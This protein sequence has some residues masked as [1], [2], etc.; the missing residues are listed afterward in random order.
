MRLYTYCRRCGRRLKGEENRVRGYGEICYLKAQ[1][2]SETGRLFSTEPREQTEQRESES[3]DRENSNGIQI[4]L[5]PPHLEKTLT[6]T[7]KKA[8]LFRPHTS[9]P[10]RQ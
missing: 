8:L 10:S 5:D 1:R 9:P 6:P 2:E 7:Y 4:N 3:R